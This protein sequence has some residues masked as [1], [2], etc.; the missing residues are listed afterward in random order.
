[1]G[2]PSDDIPFV[3]SESSGNQSH[4]SSST[5]SACAP[6]SDNEARPIFDKDLDHRDATIEYLCPDLTKEQTI[7]ANE[8]CELLLTLGADNGVA[9]TTVAGL[10]S[11][12]FFGASSVQH[13]SGDVLDLRSQRCERM[14]DLLNAAERVKKG[15][16]VVSEQ[17]Y[18]VIGSCSNRNFAVEVYEIHLAQGRHF[19]HE[20]FEDAP[21]WGSGRMRALREH[22]RCGV[23]LGDRGARWQE[24]RSSNRPTK[25]LSSA[26]ELLSVR[27]STVT[28]KSSSVSLFR[29]AMRGTS[30]HNVAER[31]FL[32]V[33]SCGEAQRV[34]ALCL[35]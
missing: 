22:P 30:Q 35:R 34:V 2:I 23:I 27:R 12:Q 18:T 20:H 32:C 24:M 7:E 16:T 28:P 9:R 31:V 33:S 6:T 11:P 1:M 21:A 13:L 15:K 19:L 10:L 29:E 17:P 4:S 26:P 25:Y 3:P 5:S 8:T 14:W